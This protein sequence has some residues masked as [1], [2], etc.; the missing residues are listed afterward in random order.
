M[1]IGQYNQL[2][3][4]KIID[5]GALFDGGE[6]GD[7]FMPKGQITQEITQGQEYKV[8]IYLDR[9]EK[10][11]ATFINPKAEVDRFSCLK[12]VDVSEVGAFLD[13]GLPKDLFVPFSQQKH[14]MVLGESYVVFLYLDDQKNRICASSRLDQFIEKEFIELKQ[15]QKVDLLIEAATPL[16]YKAIID[17]YHFGVIFKDQTPQP[18][19]V[20]QRMKGYI[21]RVREDKKIDLSLMKVGIEK[22][23]DTQQL[24]LKKLEENNGVLNLHDK[25]TPEDIFKILKMSKKVFKSTIGQLYKSKVIDI[26]KDGIYKL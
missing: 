11:I 26:K 5:Q 7:A 20:G 17:D 12:V 4:K 1:K 6:F 8:F 13:W 14:K 25:S 10:I 16:G 15:N 21:K 19:Q 22:F 24:I 3:V 9:D 23:D 2:T 18:L